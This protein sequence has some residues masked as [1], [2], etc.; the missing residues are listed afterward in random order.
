MVS[1]VQVSLPETLIASKNILVVTS[2]HFLKR[3]NPSFSHPKIKNKPP[4]GVI[5]QIVF[6]EIPPVAMANIDPE[7]NNIPIKKL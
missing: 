7:K 2:P 6:A 5:N 3:D 1:P 4:S